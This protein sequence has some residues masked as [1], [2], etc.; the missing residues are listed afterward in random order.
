MFE[1]NL[2]KIIYWYLTMHLSLEKDAPS[3]TQKNESA[4][5]TLLCMVSVGQTHTHMERY[6]SRDPKSLTSTRIQKFILQ[7]SWDRVSRSPC[8]LSMREKPSVLTGSPVPRIHNFKLWEILR[9]SLNLLYHSLILVL[10][11]WRIQ[12]SILLFV[13]DS[14]L[15]IKNNTVLSYFLSFGK[16]SLL[17][18][19]HSITSITVVEIIKQILDDVK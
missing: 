17:L 9:L 7:Q 12:N 18:S 4:G 16:I 5:F 3:R 8:A 19:C 10:P 15:N 11:S 1:L 6:G 2:H 14:L 13:N